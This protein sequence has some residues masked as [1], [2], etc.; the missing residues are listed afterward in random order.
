MSA[1]ELNIMEI[2]GSVGSDPNSPSLAA[3][4]STGTFADELLALRRRHRKLSL[5]RSLGFWWYRIL[6]VVL[7]GLFAAA[8]GEIAMLQWKILLAALLVPPV[9]FLMTKRLE[10]GLVLL[11][12][13]ISPLVPAAFAVKSVAVYPSEAM[14]AL[15]LATITTFAAFQVRPIVWPSL[16][17]IWPQIGL[18]TLAV[19]SEIM[20]QVTW[21]PRVP[22]SVNA[23]P[24]LYS[25]I[26]GIVQYCIPLVTIIVTTACLTGK[27]NW[28]PRLENAFLTLSA[29]AALMVCIEFKRIGADVYMFRYT[30]PMIYYMQLGALAQYMGLGAMVAYA[31]ALCA[32][33]WRDR[34]GYLA[35]TALCGIAVYFTLENS[36]WVYMAIGLIAITFMVSRRLFVTLCVVGLPLTPVALS[37]ASAIQA[38]KGTRD[39][40][41]LTVW[42]DML[43]IWQQRPLLGVGPGNVWSY[44]QAFTHLPLDLRNL[45]S[46]GLG[47]AHN[48]VLQV[49]TELG[50]LGVVCYYAFALLVVVMSVRLYR[51]SRSPE[52]R[53]DRILALI[54]LGLICGSLAADPVS[55]I[56]FLP[57]SQI[58]GWN[59]LPRVLSTWMMFGC[60]IYKDQLWRTAQRASN[61]L[62]RRG[63]AV[64]ETK[65]L[66]QREHEQAIAAL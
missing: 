12:V 30:E 29:L 48:G 44:D 47:V 51:R 7:G 50:P 13:A 28:I 39:L 59:D 36:R 32:P 9:V 42:Q 8:L 38:V 43:R 25:E 54:C 10:V 55:G 6:L 33:R 53:H 2:I 17:A 31:R 14:L 56:F 57:P 41:R 58:G 66:P 1:A 24:V 52:N 18:I 61:V 65:P 40:N 46:D 34:L 22:H 21:I 64:R 15:L 62:W 37:S 35:L 20:I 27:D 16:W 45:T 60:L 63:G 5:R 11:G 19:I 4:N 3:S 49:L 26:I 23:T